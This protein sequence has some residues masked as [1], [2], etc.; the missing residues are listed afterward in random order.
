MR[1][2]ETIKQYTMQVDGIRFMPNP[3]EPFL[4]VYFSENSTL[5]D[6]YPR[7]NIRPIDVRVVTVP[8][9]KVPR[10]RLLPDVRKMF[11]KYKLYAYSTLQPIPPGRSFFYD[12]SQYVRAIDT[13]YKPKTY[14]QRAGFLI[15]HIISTAF[16]SYPDNYQKILLYSIDTTKDFF[17]FVNRKVFP[18]VRQIKS[19]EILFDHL[20]VNVMSASGSK[21]RLLIKDGEFKFP[22]VLFYLR[23]IKAV[24]LEAEEE[25]EVEKATNSAFQKIETQVP[26]EK[27]SQIKG[28]IA[29]YLAKDDTALNKIASKTATKDEVEQIVTTAVLFRASG[30]ID[31]AKRIAASVPKEKKSKALDAV[32]K[33]YADEIIE[34]QKPVVLSDDVVVQQANIPKAVDE[35]SPAHLFQKRQIDFETNLKKDMTNSFK[36]LERK[37]VPL[38]V[39]KVEILPRPPS[40]GELA[41]GDVSVLKTTLRDEFG[42]VHE[43][44]MEIPNIDPRSGTFRIRGRRKCLINQIVVC[45]ISFPRPFDSRFESS[46]SVFHIRS[47]RTRKENYLECMIA[48][49]VLPFL[50]V[51]A[52]SFGFDESMK[53]YGINYNITTTVPK[54]TELGC[55][56]DDTNYII[57]G[58]VDSDLKRELCQSFIRLRV[59]AYRITSEFGTR[60]YFNDLIIAITGRIDAT[61]LVN[62]IIENIVDPIVKQ[63]LINQQLPYVL[64]RIMEYMASRAVTGFVQDRNDLAN[65]RIRNSEVLVHLAQKQILSAYTVYKEQVLAG[66]KDAKLRIEPK[67]VLSDFNRSEIVVDME[68]ANPLEEMAV[69]TRVSPVGRLVGGIPDKRAIQQEALNVHS[70]YFGNL[71]PLDTPEGP[72]VGL[73]QQ[74]SL[75]ATL[76]SARGLITSKAITD[77]ENAGLLSTSASMIPFIEN[78]DGARVLMATQQAKQMLPLKNPEPP[79]VQS[80]Y[81]SVLTNVLSDSFIKRSPCDGKILDVT[82]EHISLVCKDGKRHKIDI[83][84]AHLRSGSGKDTLSVFKPKV[85]KNQLVK[86]D[87]IIAE[88]ACVTR[89]TISL[90][91]TLCVAFMP[92]KGY[93]FEDGIVINERLIT[94]DKLTSLHGIVEEVIVARSDRVLS[95]AQVGTKTVKGEP[96]LRKTVGEIEQ[97]IG[98][99]EEEEDVDITAGQFIKKSPGGTIVEIE[100]LSNVKEDRFPLLKDLVIKTNKKYGKPPKEKFMINGVPISGIIVRFKIE[101]E[102]KINFG[103][104]L[105]N[106]FGNK[107]I[108]SLVEK[109]SNMPRTPWG[110]TVEVILNPIGIVSRMNIGQLYEMY[111]GLISKTLAKM[112][113]DLNDQ[114]K[115]VNLLKKVLPILDTTKNRAF[116]T[117]LLVNLS[118]LSTAKFKLLV[119]QIKL[120]KSMP[121]IIPPFK[122]PDYRSIGA[123]IK[124]LGLKSAYP[125]TLP[126]FNTK[127]KKPVPVGYMYISKLEHLGT[128]KIFARST[129]PVA[130]KTRQPVA[131]RRRGGGQRVGEADTYAILSYNCPTL[132][133]EFFGPLSDDHVTKGEVISDILHTGSAK[134][135]PAKVSPA[136]DL[137]NSYFISL[138]LSG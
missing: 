78:N 128:E 72:N 119:D 54:K 96:L 34:P 29:A 22:R 98:F 94:E 64:D 46:Y 103:D 55:K 51:I 58:N 35:K 86:K 42:K 83:T 123:A 97:L 11:R 49:Y 89:G 38:K 7:L 79:A 24:S 126:E 19:E 26:E 41:K 15:N 28:A 95:I 132:L 10:T 43:V 99:E 32:V 129:G 136:K 90:G 80:G 131:G 101:Q 37:E 67:A 137:L 133:S 87:A 127:T 53:Q 20:L 31:R 112:I 135:R 120:A 62:S 3:K 74:L 115:I 138:M 27:K 91:R 6:D 93:N 18:I 36:V 122:A 84:P 111:C 45:P 40:A 12:V 134:F 39:T 21:Y 117:A 65:Q 121:I 61:Y 9:T 88:G 47:K 69:I 50:V 17:S 25:E 85:V 13:T 56:L 109:D 59:H 66:N 77:D 108:V 73:V 63:V 81:E 14:R 4:I 23:N 52:Y 125:L 114:K 113:V 107:G 82:L 116:S 8:V 110:E 57:F 130:E 48:S 33:S 30:D 44:E 92:Y 76:T 60:T 124:V 16:S 100:V 71:D 104:K 2:F 70:S 105:C 106:R 1:R 5:L 118:K 68:Y 75:G 102:L